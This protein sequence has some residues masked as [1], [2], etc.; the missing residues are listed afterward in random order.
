[1][2]QVPAGQA[3]V[4]C[5]TR[6]A[7]S[8]GYQSPRQATVRLPRCYV[9]KALNELSRLWVYIRLGDILQEWS[10]NCMP[11]SIM[12][13]ASTEL[14]CATKGCWCGPLWDV[15]KRRNAGT[16]TRLSTLM[17]FARLGEIK[18]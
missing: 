9:A 11:S 15:F 17:I 14:L 7:L 13:S 2:N 5:L 18:Q 4:R 10:M 6:L 1:M 16:S 12:R 3:V 8:T